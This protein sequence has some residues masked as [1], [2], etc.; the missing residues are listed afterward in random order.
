MEKIDYTVATGYIASFEEI[1]EA[2]E[3]LRASVKDDILDHEK[4]TEEPSWLMKG[5]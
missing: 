2:L 4:V 3:K 1:K 5:E